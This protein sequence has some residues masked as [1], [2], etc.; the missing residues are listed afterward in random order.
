[1]GTLKS[2]FTWKFL[3]GGF[4]WFLIKKINEYING[5]S[6][7]E[8]AIKAIIWLTLI[9]GFFTRFSPHKSQ[10]RVAFFDCFWIWYFELQKGQ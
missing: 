8:A 1:M 6:K 7:D 2:I 10:I 5:K 4:I 3:L 9:N